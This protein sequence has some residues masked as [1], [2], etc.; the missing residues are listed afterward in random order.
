MW[1]EEPTRSIWCQKS[2]LV[3]NFVSFTYYNCNY[4]RH[5]YQLIHELNSKK[6]MMRTYNTLQ[7][8]DVT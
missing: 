2:I 4:R 3:V 8:K 1:E 6:S 7:K 5:A